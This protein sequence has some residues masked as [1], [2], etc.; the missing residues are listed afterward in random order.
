MRDDIE[1]G[2]NDWWQQLER[3]SRGLGRIGPDEICCEGLTARQCGLL[4]LL[5]GSEGMVLG[6]LAQRAGVTASGLSRAL[7]RLQELGL[8]ER[9][10]GANP[11]GR[12]ALVRVT[13][14]GH[15]VL[16]RINELMRQRVDAVIQ[17]IPEVTRPMVW[18]A[19]QPLIEAVERAGGSIL[20]GERSCCPPGGSNDEERSFG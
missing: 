11:D 9:V 19:L 12:A 5:A 20:V 3:L 2:F 15:K 10:R 16:Q 4:R 17:A 13:G 14:A 1:P 6:D 8:V 18:H 7:D